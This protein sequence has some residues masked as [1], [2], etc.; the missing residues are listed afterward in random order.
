M[1]SALC[2]ELS[3]PLEPANTPQTLGVTP[4]Y[5]L[6]HN[7]ISRSIQ[8]LSATAK[9]LT[10]MA[11]AL[12]PPDLSNLT[13]AFTFPEFCKALDMPIGG[14]QYK[15]F[16]AAVNECMQCVITIETEPNEKGKKKWKK[17]TWF[18]RAEFDEAT[19]K[20]TMKFSSE[21]AEVLTELKW[22]YSKIKLQDF[23]TLQSR[24]A[25]RL[26]EIALSFAYLKGK[27]GNKDGAWYFQWTIEDLRQIL[28]VPADAYKETHL[29][30][31]KVIDAPIKEINNAGLGLAINIERVKQG[32]FLVAL[33][34]DCEQVPRQL[35]AKAKNGKKATAVQ[36]ELP[37]QNP[38]LAG[39]REEKELQHL[40]ERYPAEF[41]ELYAV[42]LENAP[43]FLKGKMF[44]KITAEGSALLKLREKYGIVK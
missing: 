25:L 41:A 37:E 40:K 31:Q 13:A 18:T 27:Q 16:K 32:R 1:S 30:K 3:N 11:M 29:F 35:T 19:G 7:A 23:G 28:G 2:P 4:R 9:K 15:I 17:F 12:I 34:F 5:V 20:A 24:Y 33:R 22:V 42:E 10:A 6:Q 21:L 43:P 8:H 44:S 38:K 14:E 36:L 39:Q 26:Y